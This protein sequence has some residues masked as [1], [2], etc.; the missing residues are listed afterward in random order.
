MAEEKETQE[1]PKGAYLQEVV[2]NTDIILAYEGKRVH[3]LDVIAQVVNHLEK[4]T[5]FKLEVPEDK[6]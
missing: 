1:V 2:T 3:V 6:E 5:G 4:Q